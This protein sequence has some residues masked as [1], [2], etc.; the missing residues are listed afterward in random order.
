MGAR[1]NYPKDFKLDT[2]GFVLAQRRSHADAAC[3]LRIN[4]NL[5]SRWIKRHR[6]GDGNAFRG[7]AKLT[8]EQAEIRKY[9]EDVRWWHHQ[10]RTETQQDIL[11]YIAMLHGRWWLQ[12]TLAYGSHNDCKSAVADLKKAASLVSRKIPEHT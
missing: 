7:N 11:N 2:I 9:R 5:L 4:A 3:N 1:G 10:T 6:A 8:A 12:S